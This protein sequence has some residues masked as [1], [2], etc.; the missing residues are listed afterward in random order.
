MADKQLVPFSFEAKEVVPFEKEAK[1]LAFLPPDLSPLSLFPLSR[2]RSP[3]SPKE[4]KQAMYAQSYD[5]RREAAQKKSIRVPS[6]MDLKKPRD[7]ER[8]VDVH[9]DKHENTRVHKYTTSSSRVTINGV[10]AKEPQIKRILV[11]EASQRMPQ[12]QNTRKNV[13]ELAQEVASLAETSKEIHHVNTSLSKTVLELLES[14]K[15]RDDEEDHSRDLL[16][17]Y[18]RIKLQVDLQA[19]KS[20]VVVKGPFFPQV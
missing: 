9:M 12:K 13:G 3:P 4:S 20:S 7:G 18:I 2:P 6:Y 10:R 1:P 5:H 17:V 15:C 14:K 8:L 11:I 16:T 19:D